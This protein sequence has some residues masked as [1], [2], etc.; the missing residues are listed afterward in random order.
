MGDFPSS[1]RGSLL[2]IVTLFDKRKWSPLVTS[3]SKCKGLYTRRKIKTKN[4]SERCI[5]MN[6]VV[7]SIG[8]EYDFSIFYIS[9]RK[10][11]LVIDCDSHCPTSSENE[12]DIFCLKR[13]IQMR[14]FLWHDRLFSR[15]PTS[16]KFPLIE[17]E[18]SFVDK[19]RPTT[20]SEICF[21]TL[22]L[23]SWERNISIDRDIESRI[24]SFREELLYDFF[25]LCVRSFT[26]VS[27]SYFPF[28]IDKVL[29]RPVVIVIC[30]PKSKIIIEN[31]WIGYICVFA[32]FLDIFS[33]FFKRKF[34]RMHSDDYKSLVAIFFIP[35]YEIWESSLA[36]YTWICPKIDNHDFSAKIL[37]HKWMRI[38]PL[39]QSYLWSRIWIYYIQLETRIFVFC[40]FY[41]RLILFWSDKFF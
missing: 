3:K 24:Y 33:L 36:I 7:H 14:I 17:C 35:F 29:R 40:L 23:F 11:Y 15:L 26:K 8:I 27:M 2:V 34:R 18:I 4:S 9:S 30:G 25:T 10:L 5:S 20:Q 41:R 38:D 6:K 31:N 19:I 37:H 1:H 22:I 13:K 28:F 39:C 16:R 21:W 32:R 12:I